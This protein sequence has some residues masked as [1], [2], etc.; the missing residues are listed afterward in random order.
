M[1][2]LN[3][4]N[5]NENDQS[6]INSSKV[7]YIVIKNVFK[8]KDINE[9]CI[10]ALDDN[11]NFIF[12]DCPLNNN[13]NKI[14]KYGI[15]IKEGECDVIYE[16]NYVKNF[17]RKEMPKEIYSGENYSQ[18]DTN[19]FY[20]VDKTKIISKILEKDDAVYLITRP[21]RFGKS[22]N[23]RMINEFFEKPN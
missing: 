13:Y 12:N 23:L 2:L 7:F 14:I 18:F 3:N 1:Y 16:I 22:L 21:R 6:S 11:E 4:K 8:N 15:A 9:G 10:Q 5:K 17:K 19:K 20:F